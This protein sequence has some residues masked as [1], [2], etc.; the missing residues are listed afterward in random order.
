[1]KIKV[2][3]SEGRFSFLF[4]TRFIVNSL[5][6]KFVKNHFLEHRPCDT[7]KSEKRL[8]WRQRRQ[9][10]SELKRIKRKYKNWVLLEVESSDGEYV[11]ITL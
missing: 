1:M 4:P 8:T 2:K 6:L 5:T 9:L 7:V 3:S 11:K 10:A